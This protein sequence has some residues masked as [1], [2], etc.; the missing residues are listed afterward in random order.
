MRSDEGIATEARAAGAEQE[1]RSAGVINALRYLVR[2][3]IGWRKLPKDFP[4]GSAVCLVV[5]PTDEPVP[6]A[7]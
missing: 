1:G 7:S 3:R 5:S 2:S 6:D 4:A